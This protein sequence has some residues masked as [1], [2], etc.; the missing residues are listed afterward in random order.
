MFLTRITCELIMMIRAGSKKID[1]ILEKQFMSL[2][3]C[4]GVD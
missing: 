2:M 3:I 1:L 4:I